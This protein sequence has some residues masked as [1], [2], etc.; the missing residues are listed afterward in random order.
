VSETG[1]GER[2]FEATDRRLEQAR[3]RGD[4]PSVRE[5]P[6]AGVYI[7]ALIGL[8]LLGG[9]IARRVGE[10]V[11]P[12]LEQPDA[13]LDL[14]P[15]GWRDAGRA[16][17]MALAL[18]IVPFFVLTMAG[19]LLPYVMHN[20]IAISPDRIMPKLSNLSPSRGFK[21]MFSTRALFEFGTSL[22]KMAVI[23]GATYFLMRPIYRGSVGLVATDLALLPGMLLHSVF[24]I[25]GAA[26]LVAV[27]VAAV[28]A[29]YQHWAYRR[30]LRMTLQEM[31]D[32]VRE[33][34][35]DPRVKARRRMLRR[36]RAHRRMMHEVPKATVIIANPTHFAGSARSRESM[37]SRLW[38]TRRWRGLCM[39]RSRSAMSSRVSISRR[40]RRLLVWC[41]R[42][43]GWFRLGDLGRRLSVRFRASCPGSVCAAAFRDTLYRG[44][45]GWRELPLVGHGGTGRAGHRLDLCSS[46]S[47]PAWRPLALLGAMA[48]R[49]TTY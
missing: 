23:A 46:E 8:V 43:G 36:K 11:L 7:G 12:M 48:T 3:E 14:T 5:A 35:G 26:T 15:D 27:A 24:L 1:V 20:A 38:K 6:V 44:H 47:S 32:E 16:V 22:A 4:V 28:D 19:A 45:G 2:S 37:G 9:T 49:V 18:A 10:I 34:E 40:S 17:A 31:K 41:G 21:R 25:V 33:S 13:L 39:P 42:S 30:R 29:P